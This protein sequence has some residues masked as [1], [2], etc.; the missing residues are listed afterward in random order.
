MS[1]GVSCLPS[2]ARMEAIIHVSREVSLKPCCVPM[3]L[4]LQFRVLVCVLDLLPIII[5]FSC[6]CFFILWN[7]HVM[8]C[9]SR[10]RPRPCD[11][12][13]S[14]IYRHLCFLCQPHPCLQNVYIQLPSWRPLGCLPELLGVLLITQL[15][16]LS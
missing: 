14:H 4:Q 11:H 9:V 1:L 7:I 5:W 15:H 3:V 6:D 13:L 2:A 16:L 12:N 10:Q 8:A